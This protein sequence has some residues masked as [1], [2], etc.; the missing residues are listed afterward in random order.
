MPETAAVIGSATR[1][2]I[3]EQWKEIKRRFTAPARPEGLD[4]FL[5]EMGLAS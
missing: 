4:S 2:K 1:H 5:E 3:A